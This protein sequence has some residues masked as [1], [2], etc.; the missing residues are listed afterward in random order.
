MRFGYGVVSVP[1]G[2]GMRQTGLLAAVVAVAV[3]V[4]LCGGAVEARRISRCELKMALE[5]VLILPSRYQKFKN[6][7]LA[8]GETRSCFPEPTL[9]PRQHVWKISVVVCVHGVESMGE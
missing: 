9:L 2:E 3:A 7:I 6:L 1:L 4:L 5:E 8:R